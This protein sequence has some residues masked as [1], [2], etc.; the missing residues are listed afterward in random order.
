LLQQ[1]EIVYS[2]PL[3]ACGVLENCARLF[4][5][6][7]RPLL[8]V[9]PSAAPPTSDDW[10]RV[11]AAAYLEVLGSAFSAVQLADATAELDPS[12]A[13][14]VQAQQHAQAELARLQ[15]AFGPLFD[16]AT[17]DVT[18]KGRLAMEGQRP[19]TMTALLNEIAEWMWP[20]PANRPAP[21]YKVLS[22]YAHSSLDAQIALYEMDDSTGT[23]QV[24]RSVPLAHIDYN[25]AVAAIVFQRMFARLVGFY[26][27]DEA[28]LHAYSEHLAQ[29]F[30]E[31]FTYGS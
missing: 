29:V 7:V 20:D 24:K 14:F 30:P 16:P 13:D 17:T 15:G 31:Q 1:G 10:K 22:G 21:L 19:T 23:R 27:W 18:S 2:A 26:A 8:G 9:D 3:L 28:P 6:Y 4:A 12:N 25:V 11:Y 5:I